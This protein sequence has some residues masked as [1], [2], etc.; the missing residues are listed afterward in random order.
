MKQC[1]GREGATSGGNRFRKQ[2][3]HKGGISLLVSAL[4][5]LL[6][7]T[8]GFAQERRQVEG[9][10][11]DEQNE[12]LIGLT[13]VVKNT[14]TGTTTR[15]DGTFTISAA[16]TD[17]L[18]FSYIGYETR[19]VTVG[20]QANISITMKPDAKSL[21]EVVVVGYG[22][23]KRADVT[24]SV[25]TV[26]T[27]QLTER[28]VTSIQN[29]LQG[30]SPGLT[31]IQR[32]GDVGSVGS[33]TVRGRT[34]L[35]SPGPMIIID[36]IP[37]SDTELAALNP[38]D[39]ENMS[40][41]KDASAA[42]I[43][44]S[45]AANGVIVVSTRTGKN[46]EKTTVGFNANYGFQSPTRLPEYMDAVGYARF[47]N[48]AM[49]N[50][51]KAPAYT[52]EQIQ[53]FANGSE[54]DMYPNTNWYDLVLRD[55]APQSDINLNISSSGKST[56]Y[57][58]GAS[59]FNQQSLLPGKDM[60]RYTVKLNTDTEV[61]PEI[62]K[63]GTNI[64]FIRQD[65][66]TEGAGFSW[67]ELN[68][69][70]PVTV[71]RH[72]DGSWGSVSGGSA[73]ANTAARNQ[74]R[75]MDEGGSSWSRNNYLQT[76]ANA[77]LTPLE[78]LTINGL[79]SLKYSNLL[80]WSFNSRMDPI[81]NF[82]TKQPM[83][84]SAVTVNQMQENWGRRQELLTQG[85]ASYERTFGDH[86]GKIMVGA[87][88][89]SNVYRTAFLGRKNFPND[90]MNTI[91]TGSASPENIV[92]GA[93]S[94]AETQWAIRSFFGR[95]NYDFKNKYLFEGSLRADYSSRFHPDQRE[96]V[97]PAFS[98]GWRLSE[99]PFIKNISW[100]DNL[101]LRGS[102]G[103]LGNQDVVPPGN[104]YSLLNTGYAYNFDGNAVDGAWQATGANPLATWEK[105]YM[106]D[107]GIDFSIF[108][109]KLDV[110]A[111]YYIKNTEGILMQLPVLSTYGLAAPFRNAAETR[112]K[113]IEL[114]LVHNGAIGSDFTYTIGANF[115][116][117][118]NEIVSLGGVEERINGY[119]IERVGESVGAFYGY[120][121]EGLFVNEEDV[122]N[123]AFQ[124]AA[125]KPGDIKYADINKDGV[126]DAA[127][128]VILGND[129]P[130]MTYGL[131]LGASYKGFDLN[132]ITYGVADVD[133]YL[134]SEAAYPFFNGA[135][136]KTAYENRWTK[137]NPDP[138]AH[139]PRTLI[140]ADAS[141]N[142]NTSSFWL[143]SG[144]YF[145]VRAITLGYNVPESVSSKLG[146]QSLRVYATSNNPFTIMGDD[147]LTDYDPE[148]G[149]G[150]GGYPGTKTI[151]FGVNA[152]F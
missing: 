30:V 134:E 84:A 4:F 90:D 117:I 126:I 50:A 107:F 69:S 66:D 37:A 18:V 119:W 65:Y 111:D 23:Q 106:T 63:V 72:S 59:Y 75:L 21:E 112:N 36:G 32:P 108:R 120:R 73:N 110:V 101:K 132:V 99:E 56:S 58:L 150:R 136:I 54:P 82:I 145:R 71:A 121:S 103:A 118:N 42:S 89:E 152:R 48:E 31:V 93:N 46:T 113:G 3:H 68:R 8:T 43:Y 138:N 123:H 148:F 102:W 131:N 76:A 20:N 55:A 79:A 98:A 104:Y 2:R 39:I 10:V 96:A 114:N 14:T 29:A 139:F 6:S 151:S 147:R 9:K 12:P 35:G 127:D 49:S 92:S 1:Y 74:L 97:F 5:F 26:D 95:V 130:W 28:P 62:L 83:N 86:T 137:E 44:G 64:S 81:V 70:L 100:I 7:I 91:G 22:T 80:N 15:P 149:S 33:I 146:M 47:Y 129:V 78:G 85:T 109:G 25:A 67:T 16:P 122:Q 53:K 51:G 128:R 34:N 94:T 140:S 38:N 135:N 40:V 88:Q 144:S 143:F 27:K 77:S 19:E 105:V 13:V 41:L 60:D 17:V 125:T 142:Y 52:E 11:V 24:G 141:H 61:F 87:S 133:T 115:S 57:Y 116:K 124:S 45:R